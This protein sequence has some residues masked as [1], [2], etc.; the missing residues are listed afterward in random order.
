MKTYKQ[1]I[2]SLQKD[3]LRLQSLNAQLRCNIKEL[4]DI[5]FDQGLMDPLVYRANE[6][7]VEVFDVAL[8][9]IRVVSNEATQAWDIANSVLGEYEEV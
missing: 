4:Q 8:K 5:L 1:Q 2:S 7:K 9:T 3:L 6:K